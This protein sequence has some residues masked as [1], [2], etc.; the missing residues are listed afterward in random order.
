MVNQRLRLA[1]GDL[2]FADLDPVK[3]IDQSGTRPVLII[4]SDRYQRAQNR[5]IVVLAMTSRIRKY[6]FHL[7]VQPKE[8]G[9]DKVGAIMC[10]QVRVVSTER[11]IGNRPAGR[12][13]AATLEK[14]EVLIHRLFELS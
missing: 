13:S 14:V 1:R 7:E 9:L 12:V 4:S 10:D 11:L 5:L 3:G 8:T 2:W 6:P